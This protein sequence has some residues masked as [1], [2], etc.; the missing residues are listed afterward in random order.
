MKDS[1]LTNYTE[2][3]LQRQADDKCPFKAKL[4]GS[5]YEPP[6]IY[7]SMIVLVYEH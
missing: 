1:G 6:D 3:I 2:A 7:I 5:F 4:W